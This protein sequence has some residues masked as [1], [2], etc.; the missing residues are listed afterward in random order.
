MNLPRLDPDDYG[1]EHLHALL[2]RVH[3]DDVRSFVEKLTNQ[4]LRARFHTYRE[5]LVG[6]HLQDQGFDV[7]YER[8]VGDQTPDW[9]LANEENSSMEVVDVL[10]LH[11]RYEKDVEISTAIRNSGLWSGWITVPSDHIYR[12]LTDKAGQYSKLANESNTPFV[13]AVYG[14]FTASIAPE[15]MEHMLFVQHG[16]WFT[17]TTEVSGL[18]YCREKNF[19]F[20]YTY[21]VNPHA[22]HQSS[23]LSLQLPSNGEA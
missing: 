7:R 1:N 14:E 16:G 20:E 8:R 23:L 2:R 4:P 17:S 6:V 10:T 18:I 22:A 21:Y 15:E 13:L 3:P 12:K 11:Q 19:Q 5:L 9:C